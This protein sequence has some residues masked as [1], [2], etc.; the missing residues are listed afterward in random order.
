MSDLQILVADDHEVVRAGLVALL[1]PHPGWQICGQARDGREAVQLAAQLKPD[2]AIVD[3][4]MP[5][6]NGLEATRQILELNPQTRI[7]ILT[8]TDAEQLAQAALDAGARAFILKTDASRDLVAAV[9]A[10][11]ANGTF[12][13]ARVREMLMG[14]FLAHNRRSS[15]RDLTLST[16]TPR[17]REIVQLLAEGRTT[18]E[19]AA[20]LNVSV[21]TAETHRSNL[22]RKLKIHSTSELVLYAIRN[23][24]VQVPLDPTPT[25][26]DL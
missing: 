11:Q 20:I 7:L 16:I 13:T 24:I 12:F 26:G 5:S 23:R 10:L 1:K 9:E 18:K 4:G 2:V 17:E 25:E 22:M 3:V 8:M 21:K 6:L 19:V 14:R 15:D